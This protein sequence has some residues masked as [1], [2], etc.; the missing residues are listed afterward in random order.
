MPSEA[1]PEYSAS[2]LAIVSAVNGATF[3]QRAYD[4]FDELQFSYPVNYSHARFIWAAENRN[5]EALKAQLQTS[6]PDSIKTLA[7][8]QT[9]SSWKFECC[10][11]LLDNGA[12]PDGRDIDGYTPLTHA[13]YKFEVE[14]AGLLHS[15][16]ADIE[17]AN[18]WGQQ[19][20][21]VACASQYNNSSE[22]L[23]QKRLNM[24][25]LLMG[26]GAD[27]N[28]VDDEGSTPLHFAVASAKDV[29]L[30]RL[31]LQ[32][33]AGNVTDNFG[34]TPLQLAEKH[35][36]AELVELLR[37]TQRLNPHTKKGNYP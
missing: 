21:F 10:Q 30:V 32:F 4:L 8:H 16:G 19:P 11:L 3:E 24:V 12:D 20:L 15:Y 13:A 23:V 17:L 22:N 35:C 28:A 26:R 29:E 31:L 36:L 1:Q 14:V 18:R 5:V 37:N 33:G 6:I 27:V 2:E 9:I 7:L 25:A 34:S